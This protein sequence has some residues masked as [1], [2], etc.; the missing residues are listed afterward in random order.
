[1]KSLRQ[2]ATTVVTGLGVLMFVVSPGFAGG[3]HGAANDTM[4]QPAHMSQGRD[5][6]LGRQYGPVEMMSP[7]MMGNGTVQPGMGMVQPCPYG[8]AQDVDKD[9]SADDVRLLLERN[10]AFHG[11]KRLMVGD[12]KEASDD[13]IIAD[14]VTVDDSLVQRL[15]IDRHTGRMQQVN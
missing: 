13:T 14:I 11:N 9:L 5:G 3:T 15:Q 1:M 2:T 12:V 7:G 10:L 4:S 8:T 6:T